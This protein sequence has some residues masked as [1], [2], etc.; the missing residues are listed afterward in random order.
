MTKYDPHRNK[1]QER[2]D[3]DITDHDDDWG[4]RMDE[5][6]DMSHDKDEMRG[7]GF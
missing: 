7:L 1:E 3:R 6:D 4:N 2:N 5:M